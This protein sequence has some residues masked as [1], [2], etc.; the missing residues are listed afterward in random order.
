[1]A[2]KVWVYID[3][4]KGEA[5]HSS[6]EAIGAARTLTEQLGGGVTA[7]VAGANVQDLGQEAIRYG[8]DQVYICDDDTLEEFRA[9]PYASLLSGLAGEQKP[10]V[11][12]FPTTSRGRELAAVVAVDLQTGVLP[13]VTALEVQDGNIVATRPVYGGKLISK[14][15][16][17]ARPQL[18]TVRVRAF[19][20][21]EPDPSR[22]GNIETVS[23]VMAENDIV[24]KV[25]GYAESSGGVS[26]NDAAVI[27]SGGRGVSNNPSLTPPAGMDE[28]QLEIWRAKQGFKLI[29]DLAEVLGAAVGASRAAV[30]AGY[31]P[32]EHQV[33]QTGKVVSPDLYIACGI[34]GAIQHQ[35]GM[36][37][38]KVIVAVNKDPEAPIFKMARFGV[39][40]DLFD[41]LPPLTESLRSKLSA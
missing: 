20:A 4:F 1:M 32:Y 14:A 12:L 16:C 19:P 3:Q 17:S 18:I 24:T 11:I 9:E 30:D 27:V 10:E 23:A 40:G 36:R 6:W 34:S 41:I 5:I 8:A 2:D 13:D 15:V 38:S 35:A 22:T 37:T 25:S 26:L 7:V 28:S 29:G 39:V 31:I 33:G 21:S